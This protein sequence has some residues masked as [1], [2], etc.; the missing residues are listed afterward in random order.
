VRVNGPNPDDLEQDV[1]TFAAEVAT[2]LGR[3]VGA[4]FAELDSYESLE[5]VRKAI[6]SA[7]DVEL[8]ELV[9]PR[10]TEH[11]Q[12]AAADVRRQLRDY[13]AALTAAVP[14]TPRS[15]ADAYL[16]TRTNFLTNVGDEMWRATRS[17]LLK[18]MREGESVPEL[19]LRVQKV[20][21][22][23]DGRA[24]NIARTEVVGASNA[25]AFEQM[26]LMRGQ[27]TIT[28]EWLATLDARTRE[29]HLEVDGAERDLDE[30]FTVGG[31]LMQ[32]P[33]DPLGGAGQVCNCRCTILFDFVPN[34]SFTITPSIVDPVHNSAFNSNVAIVSAGGTDMPYSVV[35]NSEE[36]PADSPFGVL[37]EESGETVGCHESASDAK[38]QIAALMSAEKDED[39]TVESESLKSAMADETPAFSEGARWQ[40]VL[41]VEGVETG[42]GREFAPDSLVWAD[43]PIPLRRNIEDS[44]GGE[45]KTVAVLVGNIDQIWRDGQNIMGKGAFDINGEHGR[46]AY[47]LVS[48]PEK[49]LKGVSVDVDAVGDSDIELVFPEGAS[50]DDMVWPE[51][52]RFLAGRI[53]AATLCEIPAFVEAYISVDEG[54]FV[55]APEAVTAAVAAPE[56][57]LPPAA[58]FTNPQLS[59]PTPITITADGRVYGHAAL[60][61]ECHIGMDGVCVTA[62]FENDHPYYMTGELQCAGGNTVAVGQITVGTGHAPL[63]ATATRAAEHY[64]NTGSAVA[65]VAVGNDEHGIWVAGAIRPDAPASKVRD[66]RAA[67]QLS[68][69]WRRI[70]GQLRLVGLLAVNVPGFPVPKLQTRIASGAPLALVAAG[71]PVLIRVE[72]TEA[73]LEKRFLALQR[74]RLAARILGPTG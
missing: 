39:M 53:R 34:D 5:R 16:A 51:K 73:E 33:H 47:R 64:D 60:F 18:G 19:K 2:A 52:V 57:V 63:H 62:P 50:E 27:G 42:D 49:F 59:L 37:N 46:E 1:E 40:G 3:A 70:G 72:E 7:W 69:D 20:L 17:Q 35:E 22:V 45:V 25:G 10:I 26:G 55:E 8:E 32:R 24:E 28:K 9:Y 6:L 31:F 44:H 13:Q 48:S 38:D 74:K 43:L 58:W 66:L 14:G 56:I 71:R 67:G 12:S 30:P 65:D 4:G 36:C 54:D 23:T 61:G 41:A 21:D 29:D 15:L 11:W 68:G